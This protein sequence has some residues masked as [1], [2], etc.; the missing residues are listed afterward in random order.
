MC[1]TMGNRILSGA[2]TSAVRW[3]VVMGSHLV[4]HY[5]VSEAAILDAS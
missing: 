2:C 1:C 5:F 4:F 3:R